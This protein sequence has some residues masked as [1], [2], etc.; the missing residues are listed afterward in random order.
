MNFI[1]ITGIL[2]HPRMNS[3]NNLFPQ[4]PS[5]QLC[6][7]CYLDNIPKSNSELIYPGLYYLTK[8]K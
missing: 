4:F 7:F 2:K 5:I 3:I 1:C 6:F 8:I